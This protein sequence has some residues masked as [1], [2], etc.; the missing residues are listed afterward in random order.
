[1]TPGRLANI[2][3]YIES[4]PKAWEERRRDWKSRIFGF[5]FLQQAGSFVTRSSLLDP[6]RNGREYAQASHGKPYIVGAHCTTG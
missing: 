1:M 5:T 2:F 3:F 4:D 6:P